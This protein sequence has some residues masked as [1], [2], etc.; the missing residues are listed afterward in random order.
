LPNPFDATIV[1]TT[2]YALLTDVG[3]HQELFVEP[4]FKWL[5]TLRLTDGGWASTQD[6]IIATQ[7]I[8]IDF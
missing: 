7:V 8:R 3:R 5:N 6:T 4:I 2:A 1:E